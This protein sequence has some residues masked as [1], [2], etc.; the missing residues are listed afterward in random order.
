MSMFSSCLVYL[1]GTSNAS[2]FCVG[3]AW[4]YLVI[5]RSCLAWLG[6]GH[7]VRHPNTSIS[8]LQQQSE[9]AS[10]ATTQRCLTTPRKNICVDSCPFVFQNPSLPRP[11][12][13]ARY[14]A[15]GAQESGFDFSRFRQCA[16]NHTLCLVKCQTPC[17]GPSCPPLANQPKKTTH[18]PEQAGQKHQLTTQ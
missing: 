10:S 11:N 1:Q 3:L 16:T 17:G 12:P 15:S 18:Q 4:G 9:L 7:A 13:G 5:D 6:V 14:S 2:G 8:V